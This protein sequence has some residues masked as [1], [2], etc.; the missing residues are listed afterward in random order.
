MNNGSSSYP[1]STKENDSQANS[2]QFKTIKYSTVMKYLVGPEKIRQVEVYPSFNSIP[3]PVPTGVERHIETVMNSCAFNVAMAGVV[4]AGLGVV[5]AL[6][7]SGMETRTYT[8]KIPTVKETLREMGMEMRSKAKNFALIGAS[9]SAFHC[10][11]EK[12]RGVSDRWNSPA[13]GFVTGGL[14]GL[15]LGLKAGL[16]G[17]LG[18]AAFSG[19]I[20]Y[21]FGL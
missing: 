13:S 21:Y 9:F 2:H 4:G 17:G 6:F 14:M 5:I 20:D 12:H 8:E 18:F 16:F 7:M 15:R 1:T 11:I 3:T 19:A 10:L